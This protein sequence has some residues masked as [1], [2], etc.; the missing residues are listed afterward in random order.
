MNSIREGNRRQFQQPGVTGRDIKIP[1][2]KEARG[3]RRDIQHQQWEEEI[4]TR[5]NY[6]TD[7]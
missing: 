4:W 1:N 2:M 3:T 7:K 6:G 5:K